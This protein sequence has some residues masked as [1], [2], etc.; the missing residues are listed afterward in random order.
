MPRPEINDYIIY[1]IICIDKNITDCYVGSTANFNKRKLKHKLNCNNLNNEKYN[2]KIY[3]II[4]ANGGWENWSI[5]PIS[6]IKQISL[7]QSRIIEEDYREKLNAKMNSHRAYISYTQK[8][9]ERKQ[10]IA[11]YTEI[12]K[13]ETVEYKK[14][15]YELNKDRI[16][17]QRKISYQLKKL[18]Q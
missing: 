3:Q 18:N 15:W 7:T 4:R 9:E 14:K 17:E 12:N 2:L 10:Y 6:E 11:N 1:K 13:E 5:I 16:L 8:K